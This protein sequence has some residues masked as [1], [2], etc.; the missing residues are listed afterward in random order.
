MTKPDTKTVEVELQNT[1]R[2]FGTRIAGTIASIYGDKGF[3]DQGGL[4]TI[5]AKGTAGQ[6]FGAFTIDGMELIMEGQANDYVGKSQS[7]GKIVIKPPAEFG[8]RSD[9]NVVIGNTCLYGANGGKFFASG[10]CGERFAVR[11][12]GCEAVVEG[13][14]D[15]C[16]E[17]MTGGRVVVLGA[18]GRNLGAGMTGGLAYVY[19]DDEPEQFKLSV[20]ND[21][22]FQRVQSTLARKELFELI[23]EHEKTTG[24]EIA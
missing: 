16:C 15:H 14:G 10:R 9:K 6:S 1:D 21:V 12:S 20:N 4:L 17:Y 2:A 23:E 11:N 8:Q 24:S 13:A 19:C 22:R 7:G 5:Q 3:A 18:T